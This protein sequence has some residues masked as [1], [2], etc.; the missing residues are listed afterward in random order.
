MSADVEPQLQQDDDGSEGV[1][2]TTKV[3]LLDAEGEVEHILTVDFDI[4]DRKRIEEEVKRWLQLFEDAIESLPNG[5]A[6]F[7]RTHSLVTCNSAYAA[8]YGETPEAL[9]GTAIDD[10]LPRLY[11]PAS[12]EVLLDGVDLR[13]Y[14]IEDVRKQFAIVLQENILMAGTIAERYRE[15][16]H[17]VCLLTPASSVSAW[18]ENTLEQPKIQRR[19]LELGIELQVSQ[20]LV[21]LRPGGATVASLNTASEHREVAFDTLVLVT[22]RISRDELYRELLEFEDRFE[23]LRSIGDCHAPGTIAAAVYDGH[24]AARYLESGKDSYTPLYRREMPEL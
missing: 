1:T 10:L 9:A 2:W 24:A 23:T 18:T 20:E 15:Q 21:F 17:E 12:G 5:F 13:E 14:K 8:V 19:L 4:T 16:G 3:P 22:S 6:V 7:D 11:D